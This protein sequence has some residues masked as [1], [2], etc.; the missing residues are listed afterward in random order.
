MDVPFSARNCPP[1]TEET[2]PEPGASTSTTEDRLEKSEIAS[3]LV[4]EPTVIAVDTQPGL[5]AAATWLSLPAAITDATPMAR[6]ASTAGLK[7]SS[8]QAPGN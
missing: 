8:S 5:L 1:G 2:M 4:V 6:R 3:C 7:G